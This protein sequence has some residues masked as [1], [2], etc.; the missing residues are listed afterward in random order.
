MPSCF[1]TIGVICK[2]V[3]MQ[4]FEHGKPNVMH[5]A[6]EN[7]YTMSRLTRNRRYQNTFVAQPSRGS[8]QSTYV[9]DLWNVENILI[10]WPSRGS[11]KST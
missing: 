3:K 10:A 4:A 9:F 8:F 7:R 6:C 1:V 11:F 2:L 5:T